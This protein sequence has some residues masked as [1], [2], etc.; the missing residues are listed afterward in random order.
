MKKIRA[1]L[2]HDSIEEFEV[3]RE[4]EKRITFIYSYNNHKGETIQRETTENKQ[5]NYQHWFNS[6]IEAKEKL[7]QITETTIKLLHSRIEDEKQKLEKIKL[8]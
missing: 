4:T 6:K 5:S 1:N 2:L 3:I 8:L 7:I